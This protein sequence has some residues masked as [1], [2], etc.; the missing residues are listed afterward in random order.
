MIPSPRLAAC[1]SIVEVA[2]AS[3]LFISC[4][5]GFR[6]VLKSTVSSRIP[7]FNIWKD[8]FSARA[9]WVVSL[10][11]C[12]SACLE[13]QRTVLRDQRPPHFAK[14]PGR[15]RG[16]MQG[17]EAK[18]AKPAVKPGPVG[19]QQDP[20]FNPAVDNKAP[21]PWKISWS[22]W[23]ISSSP[24]SPPSVRSSFECSQAI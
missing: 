22:S 6:S 15:P 24:I 16:G 18:A 19:F 3:D 12:A 8:R 13:P 14:P 2:L 10:P 9:I 1:V 23:K 11:C 21:S 17:V 4:R 20:P 7:S 5:V